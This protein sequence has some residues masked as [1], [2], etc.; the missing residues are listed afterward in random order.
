MCIRDRYYGVPMGQTDEDVAM[1]FNKTIISGL[2]RERYGYEGVCLLYTSDA[3]DERS[4]VDLGGRRIIKK[5]N[6]NESGGSN[7][8]VQR[9]NMKRLRQDRKYSRT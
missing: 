9:R 2:L 5:K 6:K 4:S 3:A 8:T 1:S 7:C